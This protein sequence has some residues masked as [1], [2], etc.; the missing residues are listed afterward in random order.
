MVNDSMC[1]SVYLCVT[2]FAPS[3]NDNSSVFFVFDCHFNC[4]QLKVVKNVTEDSTSGSDQN[5]RTTITEEADVKL[6][7]DEVSTKKVL[8][9]ICCVVFFIF[10]W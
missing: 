1:V 6:A 8:F 10:C 9:L 7:E 5:K 4:Q 3:Y 2:A